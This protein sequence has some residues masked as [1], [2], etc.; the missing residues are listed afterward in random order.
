MNR[1]SINE[2]KNRIFVKHGNEITIDETTYIDTKTKCR[3]I[4]KY[5]GEWFAYP[6]N[7]I[8][9]EG[10]RDREQDKRKSTCMLKYGVDHQAK[11]K[12]IIN[13][14]V[15]T[16][17]SRTKEEKK[18]SKDKFKKTLI[19][20]YGVDHPSKSNE[21]MAISREKRRTPINDIKKLIYEKHGDTV[22]IDESTYIGKNKKAIFIDKDYG[23]WI[24]Y[25][26]NV[27]RGSGH[28]KRRKLKMEAT[29][30]IRYGV[31]VATQNKDIALKSAIG[32]TISGLVY[33]WK[34][35]EECVWVAS[36]EREVLYYFNT[37]KIDFKWQSQVFKI[38]DT[39]KTYRPDLY[40]IK[41]DKWVEIKGYFRK[42][43]KEKW[44]WFHNKYINSELWNGKKLHEIGIMVKLK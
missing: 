12:T 24:S 32:Q 31:K 25:V 10:H 13:K 19:E 23:S 21:I 38:D 33:H 39:G 11:N 1:I 8:R 26:Y 43:A 18:K 20:K 9:G 28:M 35:N 36:W 16:S 5:Y 4:D 34:T 22:I 40:L 2:I 14:I 37:N 44:D 41:E 27:V 29:C 42:D 3:F 17:K 7:I 30:L 6:T 15:L